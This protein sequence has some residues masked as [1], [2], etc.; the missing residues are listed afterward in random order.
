[1]MIKNKMKLAIG[2]VVLLML[3]LFIT[4]FE[5]EESYGDTKFKDNVVFYSQLQ[6]D[7][8]LWASAA[9]I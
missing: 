2:I 1:M 3:P 4:G 7:E 5:N 9:I 6:D 8:T